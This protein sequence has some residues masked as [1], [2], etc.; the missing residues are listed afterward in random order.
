MADIY[1]TNQVAERLSVSSATIHT[2]KKRNPERLTEGSHWL[3]DDKNSLLWTEQGIQALSALKEGNES[4]PLSEVKEPD[5]Q[6]LSPLERRY[7]PLIDMIADAIAPNLQRQLD[8]KVMG[9][10]KNISTDAQPLTA[11]ECV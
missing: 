10:V 6:D 7:L 4:E 2:W 1:S 8:Q 3:K 5:I 9:R 11:V